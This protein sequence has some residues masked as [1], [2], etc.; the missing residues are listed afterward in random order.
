V[1]TIL[2]PGA[3]RSLTGGA[4]EVVVTASTVREAIAALDRAHPG[5][6]ARLLDGGTLKPFIRVFVGSEDAALDAPV[7]DRD[8]IAIIPAIA[9]G[10]GPDP[11]D[12]RGDA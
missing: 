9:G 1:P 8:E 6:A 5:I 4:A 3:L 11:R 12:R 7:A 2:V 10:A